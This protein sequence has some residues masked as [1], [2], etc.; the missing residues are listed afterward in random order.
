MVEVGGSKFRQGKRL[1]LEKGPLYGVEFNCVDPRHR[2]L[3]AAVGD[4][5]VSV[6]SCQ[7]G[8]DEIRL[9]KTFQDNDR[10]EMFYC[11]AWTFD[12]VTGEPLLLVAGAA[13]VVKVVNVASGELVHHFVGHGNAINEIRVRP[14]DS[15]IFAT[16]SKDESVRVWNLRSKT[17]VLVMA[18]DE[19]HSNEV[20]G[21]DW[22]PQGNI[23]YSCGMDKY[24]KAWD[25]GPHEELLK[26]SD[27]HALERTFPTRRLQ[28]TLFSTKTVHS[29]YVDCVRSFGGLVLSKTVDNRILLWKAEL[30]PYY[31]SDFVSVLQEYNFSDCPHWFMKFS[32]DPTSTLMAIGNNTGCVYIFRAGD[33]SSKAKLQAR[34]LAKTV[35]QTAFNSTSSA[36]LACFEDGSLVKWSINRHASA[37]ERELEQFMGDT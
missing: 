4:N 30:S 23:L 31:S 26:A 9:L 16:G 14:G 34:G 32:L 37:A 20:L 35:R 12:H 21:I 27:E 11:C 33:P 10:D 8:D 3:A 7:E 2:H 28:V 5:H 17:C 22:H 18:G 1:R 19:G 13:G 15:G 25:L 36:L 24:V 6:V 29:N